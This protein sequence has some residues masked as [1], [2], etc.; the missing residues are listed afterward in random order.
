M[1]ILQVLDH[2][3]CLG[4][5]GVTETD[6]FWDDVP[7]TFVHV[8]SG[9]AQVAGEVVHFH[10]H[11]VLMHEVLVTTEKMTIYDRTYIFVDDVIIT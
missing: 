2:L 9:F 11:L 10:H 6:D 4:V 3:T 7:E 1:V 8:R 5:D